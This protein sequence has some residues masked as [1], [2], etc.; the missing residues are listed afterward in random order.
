MRGFDKMVNRYEVKW[1]NNNMVYDLW[2]LVIGD[3]LFCSFA[4]KTAAEQKAKELN[5]KADAMKLANFE[6]RP[7]IGPTRSVKN[8]LYRTPMGRKVENRPNGRCGWARV[9]NGKVVLEYA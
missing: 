2:D 6:L 1:N 7:Y 5:A 4:T 3:K 8:A 9:E